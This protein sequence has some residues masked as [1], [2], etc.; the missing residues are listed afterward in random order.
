MMIL[1]SEHQKLAFSFIIPM[2]KGKFIAAL[3]QIVAEKNLSEDIVL[4]AVKSAIS[5]AH[6]KDYG[7]KDQEIEVILRDDAQF[8]SIW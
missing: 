3:T 4:D 8:A 1:R 7:N 5:A 2:D 6:R